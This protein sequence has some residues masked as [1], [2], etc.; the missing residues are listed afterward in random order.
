MYSC[1]VRAC[2]FNAGEVCTR[3]VHLVRPCNYVEADRTFLEFHLVKKIQSTGDYYFS[4]SSR[5]PGFASQAGAQSGGEE[6]EFC[7]IDTPVHASSDRN[8]DDKN[9]DDTISEGDLFYE[10]VDES[11]EIERGFAETVVDRTEKKSRKRG[12]SALFN[13]IIADQNVSI[14]SVLDKWVANGKDLEMSEI[15]L[16]MLNLR[17]CRLYK[18]ALEVC[19]TF[20]FSRVILFNSILEVQLLK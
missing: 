15:W 1:I 7:E 12:A 6:D 18:K 16:A 13:A 9:G 4:L 5:G 11:P 20:L 2:S 8:V 10:G 14:H 3:Y 17:K 19:C